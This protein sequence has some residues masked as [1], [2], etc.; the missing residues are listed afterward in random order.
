MPAFF[1]YGACAILVFTAWLV[2]RDG[3]QHL[4]ARL[5]AAAAIGSVAMLLDQPPTAMLLGHWRHLL[6]PLAIPVSGLTWWFIQSMFDDDY[7]IDRWQ[8][9]GMLTLS[10]FPALYSLQA[11]GLPLRWLAH[12]DLGLIPPLAMLAHVVWL[13]LS[14]MRDDLVAPRRRARSVVTMLVAATLA[15][16]LL[17]EVLADRSIAAALRSMSFFVAAWLALGWVATLSDT[18]LGFESMPETRAHA[19]AKM[20]DTSAHA[21]AKT[22]AID[23]RERIF[24]DR[25]EAAMREDRVYLEPEL[26]VGGLGRRLGLPEHQLRALINNVLGY[27]NFS[28]FLARARIDHAKAALSDPALARR[29]VLSIALDSGF[30]SLATFNRAFKSLEGQTPTEFRHDALDQRQ[31]HPLVPDGDNAQDKRHEIEVDTGRN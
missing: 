12:T 4:R 3:R 31:T 28:S 16:S 24:L 22:S 18:A 26:S 19:P 20:P 2:L 23:P 14:G 25:L 27:R 30:A 10:V 11:L 1:A 29:P 15:V 9:L 8:W 21:P 6:W 7:R 5:L 13:A 17:S